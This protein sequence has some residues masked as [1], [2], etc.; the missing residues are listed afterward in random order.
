MPK[1]RGF[2]IAHELGHYLHLPH[3]FVGVYEFSGLRNTVKAWVESQPDAQTALAEGK[4][5]PQ[6]VIDRG[7]ESLHA[8]HSFS[9]GARGGA[10]RDIADMPADAAGA[11][12]MIK[13]AGLNPC[14]DALVF[15]V[16]FNGKL[17]SGQHQTATYALD[18][19]HRNIMSYFGCTPERL[20]AGQVR[21]IR[22][23]LTYHNRAHLTAAN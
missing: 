16:T 6:H 12:G 14:R 4:P 21:L 5:I 17:A 2:S 11:P 8:D 19:D 13:A 7:L 9:V 1:A 20:S 3:P 18:P 23:A 10:T 15:T 22:D